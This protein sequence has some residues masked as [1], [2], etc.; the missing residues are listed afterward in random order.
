MGRPIMEQLG[1][2]LDCGRRCIKLGD[3]D[4]QP[5]VIG[6]HGEYLL[7]LLDD[8]DLAWLAHPPAFELIAP[9]DT[10]ANTTSFKEFNNMEINNMEN[11]FEMAP[12][13]CASNE[14]MRP[15]Q[16]HLLDT[17]DVHLNKLENNLHAYVTNE[18]HNSGDRPRVLWEVYCGEARVAKIAESMGMTVECF[19]PNTGWDFDDPE[20]QRAFLER[21]RDEMPDEI[22]ISP[23]CRLWSQM[24]NLAARTE[25]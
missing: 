12:T 21:Q 24:Q 17:C 1:L 19:G 18:L 8:Y 15:M 3:M 5:T 14:G 25:S 9:A 6:A 11:L 7:P 16:R 4:W 2:V 13:E 20:H 22:Y 10:E 23:D